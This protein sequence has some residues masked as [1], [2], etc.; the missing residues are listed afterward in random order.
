ME[1]ALDLALQAS[2]DHPWVQEHPEWFTARA[3]GAT[4]Y[5]ENPPKNYQDIYPLNFD[6]DPRALRRVPA[7]LLCGWSRGEDLPGGQPAHQAAQL[8][9]VADRDVEGPH[10]DV[11]FLAEAFTRPAMMHELGRIGFTQSYT[12]FTWRTRPDRAGRVRRELDGSPGVPTTCGRTSCQHPGHPAQFLQTAAGRVRDPGGAGG[13][14]VA[15][16]GRLLRLRALRGRAG[17]ARA[18][19]STWTRRSTSCGRVT[20]RARSTAARSRRSHRLNEIRRAHPALQQ[21]RNLASTT[22]TT[23][24]HRCSRSRATGD[25]SW[26]LHAGPAPRPRRPTSPSTCRRWVPAGGDTLVVHSQMSGG[27]LQLG[28]V[29]LRPAR[30]VVPFHILRVEQLP[31][32]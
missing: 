16:L 26:W 22:A 27:N 23:T 4:A 7:D 25:T 29:L 3:D 1:L 5:A 24:S 14:D 18:A 30:A 15:D 13:D 19:R 2:P 6:N 17:R 9:A 31:G 8:L 12:Y 10:P 28:A 21:L 20:C 11:L 32:T